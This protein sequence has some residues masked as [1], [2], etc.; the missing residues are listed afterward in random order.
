MGILTSIKRDLDQSALQLV[1][2]CRDR[3]YSVAF[4]ECGN[5][6]E[7]DDLV[8][9]TLAKAIQKLNGEAEVENLFGWLKTMLLNLR[10]DDMRKAV[11][12]GTQPVEAEELEKCAGADWSTDEQIL[13]DS[14]SEAIRQAIDSLDPKYRQA[15]LMRY[16]DDFSLK[17]IAGI[18]SLP[19]GTVSRRIQIA[20]HLLAGKL[21]GKL[22]KKPV[23]AVLAALLFAG[24]SFA[25][26]K[27][28]EYVVEAAREEAR[29]N[30][31]SAAGDLASEVSADKGE[32][33][34]M[35]LK[36][37]VAAAAFA[38]AAAN[39]VELAPSVDGG[40]VVA[41]AGTW[42]N[43]QIDA[44]S[45]GEVLTLPAATYQLDV[46][47]VFSKAVTLRGAT[48]NPADVVLDG[49]GE[50]N[51]LVITKSNAVLDALT[52]ANA[53]SYP[54][55]N[56]F[57]AGVYLTGSGIVVTNCVISGYVS[58]G[59]RAKTNWG[60]YGGMQGGG[61]YSSGANTI[62]DTFVTNCLA[63]IN[64]KPSEL[65][66]AG[67]DSPS[68][69]RGAGIYAINGTKVVRCEIVDCRTVSQSVANTTD[70]SQGGGLYLSG[71]ET[72]AADCY[73]HDCKADNIAEKTSYNSTGMGGGVFMASGSTLT[74]SLVK[75]CTAGK[76]GGG[77]C[78]DTVGTV[79]GCTISENA[80]VANGNVDQIRGGGLNLAGGLVENTLIDGNIAYPGQRAAGV[81][82]CGNSTA[83][84]G[85]MNHCLF[86]NNVDTA[87]DHK[88]A[89][90]A[91]NYASGRLTV[92]ECVFDGNDSGMY[93]NSPNSTGTWLID[94]CIFTRHRGMVLAFSSNMNGVTCRNSLFIENTP[95]G[96]LV[97]M[98][99]TSIAKNGIARF[100]NCSFVDNT[101]EGSWEKM[102]TYG[103]GVFFKGCHFWNNVW[104]LWGKTEVD[105]ADNFK[106]STNVTYSVCHN[107]TYMPYD[108]DGWVSH[109]YKNADFTAAGGPQFVDEANGDYRLQKTSPMR[110]LGGPL[111]DWMGTGKLKG[112]KDIG[113]GTWQ[114]FPVATIT[115]RGKSYPVGVNLS[116]N[117]RKARV[118]AGA[119]DVG[120]FQYWLP[121]GLL[122]LLR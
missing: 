53:R 24:A 65:G 22:G 30:A 70:R 33:T 71:A 4:R 99:G 97:D 104:K 118:Y 86:R 36:A 89:A 14:D 60:S 42:L 75:S 7:A 113:D 1:V 95:S 43:A 61:I 50:T 64:L 78:I 13:K 40:G 45:A 28:V 96:R 54:Y 41:N 46:P 90:I 55:N 76:S 82:S 109:N 52:V 116:F 77:V 100:E 44:A 3:L 38:A 18:L 47:V 68:S 19:M 106:N 122:L 49:M 12:R 79:R 17:E 94:S 57:Y 83:G 105:L 119:V 27:T 111:A 74:N 20:H 59:S 26:F 29:Q 91:S 25:A 8:S 32:D 62:V 39:A 121:N 73:V 66:G 48:G 9:R 102:I 35:N 10:A 16:Y 87:G 84:G 98:G 34:K 114:E 110:G 92:F 2:E 21:G 58:A 88:G 51:A 81:N 117:N 37:T 15:M 23:V 56:Q 103:G 115:V 67:D 72:L 85:T 11:V 120:S 108:H 80:I 107:A 93:E 5:V 63:K 69:A 101:N 31:A 6:A 112:P